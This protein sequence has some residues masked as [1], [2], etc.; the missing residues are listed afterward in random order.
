M[1]GAFVRYLGGFIGDIKTTQDV[2]VSSPGVPSGYMLLVR[3]NNDDGTDAL[4]SVTDQQGN[5][6]TLIA[7]ANASDSGSRV[8]IYCSFI[9]NALSTGN[10][11]RFTSPFKIKWIIQIDVFSGITSTTDGINTGNGT[12]AQLS[13]ITITPTNAT[14]LIVGSSKSAANLVSARATGSDGG[15][16]W[17]ALTDAGNEDYADYKITTSV[18][19]Q[20]YNTTYDVSDVWAA[21]IAAWKDNTVAGGLPPSRASALQAISRAANW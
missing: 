5:T 12:S 18:A 6:Y 17:H 3:V 13:G 10:W 11:I 4:T 14:N 21:V 7:S 8:N 9:S 15:D 20:D 19:T 16:S 1:A 2:T